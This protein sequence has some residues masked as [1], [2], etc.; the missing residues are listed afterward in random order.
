MKRFA[1]V[2]DDGK[3]GQADSAKAGRDARRAASRKPTMNGTGPEARTIGDGH[4]VVGRATIVICANEG[5]GTLR[6]CWPCPEQ[7]P[8]LVVVTR[9]GCGRAL[10]LFKMDRESAEAAATR[11]VMMESY[12]QAQW[13]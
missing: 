3:T 11:L 4:T 9:E 7:Y 1:T 2:A 6:E 10:R 12:R 13:P 5:P 8:W